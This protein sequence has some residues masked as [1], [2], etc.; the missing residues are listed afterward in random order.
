[1]E[2]LSHREQV[3]Y[4][5]KHVF[6]KLFAKLSLLHMISLHLCFL[7]MNSRVFKVESTIS[8]NH[9][10]LQSIVGWKRNLDGIKK[11]IKQLHR[12]SGAERTDLLRQLCVKVSSSPM[13]Q[14]R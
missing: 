1:M 4:P 3:T 8:W 7:P 13:I 5:I 9:S 14:Q 6:W 12:E 11:N 10:D 2:D